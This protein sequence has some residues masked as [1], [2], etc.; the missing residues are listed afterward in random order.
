MRAS[1]AVG[2]Y[3][4]WALASALVAL[5]LGT[6]LWVFLEA[7]FEAT[8]RID[9]D[10]VLLVMPPVGVALG[11]LAARRTR[12]SRALHRVCRPLGLIAV[13]AGIA[14]AVIYF[15]KA[16]AV[17]GTGMFAG[18]GEVIVALF[19]VFLA[20]IGA[21]MVGIGALG[22]AACPQSPSGE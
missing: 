20:L 22:A 7:R 5:L 14:A 15:E 6:V 2:Y 9:D 18:L 11:I 19:F 16:E 12:E 13:L 3:V 21:L 17:T 1:A 8:G 10:W 4:C